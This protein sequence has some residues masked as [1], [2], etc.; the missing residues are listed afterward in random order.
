[1]NIQ[2]PDPTLSNHERLE[3]NETKDRLID[4][5]ILRLQMCI[6]SIE[7]LNKKWIECAQKSK[8]KKEDE[9]NYAQIATGEQNMFILKHEAKEAIITLTMYKKEI[10]NEIKQITSKPPITDSTSYRN[11]NLPQLFLSTFD[12]EPRQWRE[13]WNGFNAA[14]HSQ[15]IPQSQKMNYLISGTA[16]QWYS[17]TMSK[18]L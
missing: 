5:K 14:V 2:S 12:G 17:T 11:I 16:L 3:I 4:E 6:D 13:F 18:R 10:N 7:A 9:E 8:T 1:M 15:D